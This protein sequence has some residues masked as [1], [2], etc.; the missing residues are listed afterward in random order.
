[1]L[2][3]GLVAT[4][5]AAG[6]SALGTGVGWWI[7]SDAND[8]LESKLNKKVTALEEKLTDA[9]GK[10]AELSDSV[11]KLAGTVG[12]LSVGYEEMKKGLG[13]QKELLTKTSARA[14]HLSETLDAVKRQGEG[15][16]NRLNDVSE[17]MDGMSDNI[18]LILSRLPAPAAQPGIVPVPT[19]H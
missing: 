4:G 14:K 12:T 7:S 1:M 13:E 15:T 6:A 8:K 5:I 9:V 3:T 18:D 10:H 16:N 17:R 2:V 19:F 11:A